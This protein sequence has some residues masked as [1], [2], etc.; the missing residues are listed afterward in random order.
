MTVAEFGYPV[1]LIEATQASRG[2]YEKL[3]HG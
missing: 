3:M 1:E 2:S